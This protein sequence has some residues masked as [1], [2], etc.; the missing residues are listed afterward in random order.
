M[1]VFFTREVI[2][3]NNPAT[4]LLRFLVTP[5]TYVLQLP[6]G[7]TESVAASFRFLQQKY[8]TPHDQRD[9]ILKNIINSLLYEIG[10]LYHSPATA[11]SVSPTRSQQ[12]AAAF[13][14]LVQ[15]H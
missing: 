9:N 12:L 3:A 8:H 13:P 11:L 15:A 4:G 7:N 14:Q 5:S 1:S 10:P 2:T 6:A